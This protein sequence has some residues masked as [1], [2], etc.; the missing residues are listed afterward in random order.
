MS[1]KPA[2]PVPAAQ[3]HSRWG[4]AFSHQVVSGASGAWEC[5][6]VRR[7]L[8]MPGKASCVWRL[9]YRQTCGRHRGICK[10]ASASRPAALCRPHSQQVNHSRLCF[11]RIQHA[12]PGTV[13]GPC[14]PVCLHRF[15]FKAGFEG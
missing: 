14:T 12:Q 7:L 10:Q 5:P 1:A 8:S 6:V 11:P 9:L 3:V 13:N 2:G 15:K 4:A